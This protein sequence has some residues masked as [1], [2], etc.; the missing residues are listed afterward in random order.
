MSQCKKLIWILWIMATFNYPIFQA[1][2]FEN[3][4]VVVPEGEF[5]MGTSE[6]TELERPERKILLKEYRIGQFEVTNLEFEKINPNHMRSRSSACDL[7]PVTMVS[8]FEA[9]SYC[10]KNKGRLP[11]EA[12]WEKAGR[13]P[14][15]HPFSFGEYPD[16]TKSNYGRKF[17]AG[18]KTVNSFSPNGF[19]IYNMSG[20]VWEWVDNWFTPPSPESK[21]NPRVIGTFNE[22]I[23]RG[24][25]WYNS[26][27]YVNVGMRFKLKPTVK[28]NSVGFRCA[29]DG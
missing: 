8:W 25:S 10:G 3:S 12:E 22:K 29:W 15:G 11:T 14:D 17:E 24:G 1:Y 2:G 7:C 4:A 26:A 23:L 9:D 6:G 16:K 21:N 19:G 13:G 18:A 20:N 27:Y 28:L 5:L